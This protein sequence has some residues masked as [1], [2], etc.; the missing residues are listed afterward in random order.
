M[1]SIMTTHTK[2]DEE[3]VFIIPWPE[4]FSCHDVHMVLPV[5]NEQITFSTTVSAAVD[6]AMEDLFAPGEP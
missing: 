4:T 2:G 5:V 6:V 1:T 3:S